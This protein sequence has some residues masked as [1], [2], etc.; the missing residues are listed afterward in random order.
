MK[1]N[2]IFLILVVF[3]FLGVFGIKK[4]EAKCG[5]G[6]HDI[7]NGYCQYYNCGNVYD[8]NGNSPAGW[9]GCSGYG[10]CNPGTASNFYWSGNYLVWTCTNWFQGY[11]VGNPA[12]CSYYVAP[13]VNGQCNN[14]ALW[15]CYSGSYGGW[16]NPNP[17]T[18]DGANYY[19]TWS[20]TGSNGGGTDYC[21]QYVAPQAGLCGT[22]NNKTRLGWPYPDVLS[23]LP[24]DSTTDQ[25]ADPLVNSRCNF[26]NNHMLNVVS[27]TSASPK[28]TWNCAGNYG[29]A[30]SSQCVLNQ[31]IDGLCGT[32]LNTCSYGSALNTGTSDD[33]ATD[34]KW[35]C[36]GSVS[37]NG[38]TVD[39]AKPK[40]T[41]NLI[42]NPSEILQNGYTTL[43]LIT[44]SMN[45]CYYRYKNYPTDGTPYIAWTN[46]GY[47]NYLWNSTGPYNSDVLW[48]FQ[49]DDGITTL[50]KDAQLVVDKCNNVDGIQVTVPSGTTRQGNGSCTCNNGTTPQNNG[51]N[52]CSA[53]DG[54]GIIDSFTTQPNYRLI[55]RGEDCIIDW[56]LKQNA[57]GN[58]TN[59]S[60]KITPGDISIDV[61][62]ISGTFTKNSLQNTT[63]YT[64]TCNGEDEGV[65]VSESKSDRCVINPSVQ[66]I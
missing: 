66:E 3:I 56:N 2:I 26:G 42:L 23:P 60:C 4:V 27:P 47:T 55:N 8:K 7:G 61:S 10:G 21:A 38:Q 33:S 64:L 1:K 25:T 24:P 5:S 48:E 15:S 29:G 52:V 39:C 13:P 43:S 14:S 35:Q 62:N 59:L 28:W 51:T 6:S 44:S 34:Y 30:A 22:V 19:N 53:Y 57:A 16:T 45:T 41:M 63:T 32:N 36:S 50:F 49:C 12:Q 54:Q 40:P 46:L 37:Y 17:Y 58:L 20:C 65:P 11:S 9:P 31:Q 18:W